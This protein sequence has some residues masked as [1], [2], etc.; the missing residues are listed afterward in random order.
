[1][2][3]GN[4]YTEANPGDI[5][6]LFSSGKVDCGTTVLLKD[7]IYN[8]INGLALNL[9]GDCSE[10]LPIVIQAAP[11]AKPI[12]DGGLDIKTTWI[13]HPGIKDLYYT[14]L[15]TEAGRDSNICIMDSVALY[16]YPSVN[17]EVSLGK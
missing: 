8:A 11:G 6:I 12:V 13:L 10:S 17:P 16:A 5:N 3:F 2:V 4:L 9:K 1:M 15:P 7:G 14:S